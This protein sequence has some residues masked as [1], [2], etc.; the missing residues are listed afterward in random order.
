MLDRPVQ[1]TTTL[2]Q[3][4][5]ATRFIQRGAEAVSAAGAAFGIAL[6]TTPMRAATN[7]TRTAFWLGP[8]EWLLLAPEAEIA[9]LQQTLE[10]AL[11]GVPHALVDVSNRQ[12][13]LLI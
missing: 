5:S 7:G 4:P 2:T 3:A 13:A 6:P 8:D 11:A 1:P 10:T 9:A 12:T